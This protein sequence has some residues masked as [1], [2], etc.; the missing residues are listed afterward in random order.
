[1]KKLNVVLLFLW[2]GVIFTFSNDSGSASSNKSDGIADTIVSFISKVSHYDYSDSELTQII[3]NCIFI[4]RKSAHFL[5]Y[6]ILGIFILNVVKDYKGLTINWIL[7]ALLFCFFY[8]CTD[9]IH[10]LFVPDRSGRLTDILIDTIGS[11]CGIIIYR[12]IYLKFHKSFQ[13]LK[14][15]I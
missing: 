8:A 2:M 4:V 7:L 1:M 13:N 12:I 14:I 3:D 15:E 9:E 5:E 11:L 6:F 10:Q